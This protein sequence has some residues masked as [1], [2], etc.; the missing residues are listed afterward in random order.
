MANKG[1][2][3]GLSALLGETEPQSQH[4]SGIKRLSLSKIQP[5]PEQPRKLFEENALAEL[6]ESIRQ[7]GIIIPITVRSLESGYFQIIAG[8]R[9]WR[10]ARLAGLSE[11][12]AIVMEA[13]DRLSMEIALIENLQREDLNP[14]EEAEGYRMLIEDFDLT[15]EEAADRVGKSRPAVSNALRLLRLPEEIRKMIREGK[16]TGGHAR[17]LLSI[18][19]QK[20]MLAAAFAIAAGGLSAREAE[21]YAKRICETSGENKKGRSPGEV[22]VDYLEALELQLSKK[23]QRR[24]RITRGRQ[25]GKIELEFYGNDDLEALCGALMGNVPKGCDADEGRA[26]GNEQ[27]GRRRR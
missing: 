9:R 11:V 24:V 13:D 4:E 5:N 19:D 12:P 27:R 20:Q 10:A 14:I 8:E 7:H 25:K 16:L 2:G 22:T 18:E 3:R 1:L 17:P 23:L 15:Q 21:A 26:A 6:S